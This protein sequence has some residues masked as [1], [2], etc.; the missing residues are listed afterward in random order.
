M[1]LEL[2]LKENSSRD[3]KEQWATLIESAKKRIEELS[4]N[5]DRDQ[6]I[7]SDLMKQEVSSR[8][9]IRQ[10]DSELLEVENKQRLIACDYRN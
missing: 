8:D 4:S 3:S 10:I 9:R 1:S 5:I 6:V 7:I 2:F